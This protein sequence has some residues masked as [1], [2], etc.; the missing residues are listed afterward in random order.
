VIGRTLGLH[1]AG[2]LI[3]ALIAARLIGLIGLV[4]AAP[5]LATIMLG[6]RYVG[7]KMFDLPPW[8]PEPEREIKP[9]EMP[10]TRIAQNLSTLWRT[11]KKRS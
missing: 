5:V 1:P 4:L 7:R 2:V 8:P 10:W 9:P 11:L 6:G 3:A